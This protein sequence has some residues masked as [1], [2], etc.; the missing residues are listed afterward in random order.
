MD[1]SVASP[2]EYGATSQLY[3]LHS[4]LYRILKPDAH[5]QAL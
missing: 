1:D 3:N 5:G 2:F 4:D